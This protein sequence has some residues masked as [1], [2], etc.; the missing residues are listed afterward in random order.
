MELQ[1]SGRDTVHRCPRYGYVNAHARSV[2]R[3]SVRERC[4]V[5]ISDM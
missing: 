2:L 4:G 5:I 3:G 1:L